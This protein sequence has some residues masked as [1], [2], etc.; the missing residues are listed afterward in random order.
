MHQF[1][2]KGSKLWQF[3][4]SQGNFG[5][6]FTVH[7]QKRKGCLWALSKNSDTTMQCCKLSFLNGAIF[8][9][10]RYISL[11]FSPFSIEHV[12]KLTYFHFCQKDA[13]S[14]FL[15]GINSCKRLGIFANWLHFAWFLS[16]SSL[17]IYKSSYLWPSPEN[18]DVIIRSVV[19]NFLVGS[20]TLVIWGRLQLMDMHQHNHLWQIFWQSVEGCQFR[21]VRGKI[22]HFPLASP[23][24]LTLM[25]GAIVQPIISRQ[26][27][28]VSRW[29]V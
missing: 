11:C 22:C 4:N 8:Y 5:H 9:P 20:K 19:P 18:S 1:N 14:V 21:S 27:M 25:S 24:A 23:F 3:C 15:R 10:L 7:V 13:S 12:Q 28:S 16:I 17:H 26:Q 2:V 29:T 6:I